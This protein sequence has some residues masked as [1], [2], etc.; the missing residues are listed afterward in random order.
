MQK[1]PS[2]GDEAAR[3]SVDVHE[4]YSGVFLIR[5]AAKTRGIA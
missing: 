2:K 3:M 4:P 5:I 1:R